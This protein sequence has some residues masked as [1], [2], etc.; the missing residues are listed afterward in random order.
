MMV[1]DPNYARI[2]YSPQVFG[3]VHTPMK[4]RL[5]ALR[6]YD[7]RRWNESRIIRE[8]LAIYLP[9]VEAKVEKEVRRLSKIR[10]TRK[11]L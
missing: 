4:R 7:P 5:R 10:T 6:R 8:A 9:I 1:I 2:K 3:Y 11:R